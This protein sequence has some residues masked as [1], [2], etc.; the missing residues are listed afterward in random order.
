MRKESKLVCEVEKNQ[1]DIDKLTSTHG[2]GSGGWRQAGVGSCNHTLAASTLGFFWW[3]IGMLHCA[4]GL[5][6]GS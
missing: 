2:L 3:T 1:L 6:N 4:F 5:G